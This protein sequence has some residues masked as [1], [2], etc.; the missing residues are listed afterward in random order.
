MFVRQQLLAYLNATPPPGT[1][2]AIFGLTT[3]LTILQGFTSDPALLKAVHPPSIGKNSPLLQDAVGGGGIQNSTADDMEDPG[4]DATI[5]ANMRQ[6]D[7][8][9]QSFQLQLRAKYTLDAMSQLARYL[10]SIPGRK[11]LIWFSGSFPISILPDATGTL[12][13]PFAVMADSEEEFREPSISSPALR[14][15]SIPSTLADSSTP[16]SSSAATTRNYTRNPS[17][18]EPGPQQ[19]RL[20]HSLRARHHAGDGRRHRRPRLLQHQRPRSGRRHR[21]H[22]RLQLLH[23]HLHPHQSRIA[24]ESSARSRFS[25][26]PPGSQLSPTATATTPT[27][28]TKALPPLKGQPPK[29]T[30]ADAAVTG[31][32][33]TAVQSLR[34]AIM[35]G[36]PTP[37]EIIFKVAVL[38]TG[39]PTQ[40]EDTPAPGNILVDKAHGPFRRYSV[41]YAISPSDITFLRTS[42]GKIHAN[43]EARRL[44]LQS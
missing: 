37:T 32:T 6:F 27:T 40:T 26:P 33:P 14:S 25:W 44:R 21:H 1:R 7:A 11:N 10:S 39:P 43:F 2:I 15:P 19:I 17:P 18:H 3:R 16:R 38:P 41:S 13:D 35:R 31:A 5:V 9:Q 12:P 22:R 34:G 30:V 8:Q 29:P 24:T 23:P 4:M 20:R 28:P 36:S 42:D